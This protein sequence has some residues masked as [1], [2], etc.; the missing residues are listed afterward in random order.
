[1][2]IGYRDLKVKYAA[3]YLK[4]WICEKEL[5]L[6]YNSCSLIFG[7]FK[8]DINKQH[9]IKKCIDI[10]NY[11]N[12]LHLFSSLKEKSF[13]GKNSIVVHCTEQNIVLYALEKGSK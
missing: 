13:R 6:L 3:K 4:N 11:T 9:L 8:I 10:L 5:F 1:M 12:L 7:N 2:F